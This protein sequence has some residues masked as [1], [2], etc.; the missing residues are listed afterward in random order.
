MRLSR[1]TCVMANMTTG[2]KWGASSANRRLDSSSVSQRIRPFLIRGVDIFGAFSSHCHSTAILRIARSIARCLVLVPFVASFGIYSGT[3]LESLKHLS[4]VISQFRRWRRFSIPST[5][6][7]IFCV[8]IS[9]RIVSPKN[10]SQNVMI[11]LSLS[12]LFLSSF[13]LSQRMQASLKSFFGASPSC[14]T[15]HA[16]DFRRS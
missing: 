4:R 14:L 12:M 5:A 11:L 6:S 2:K 8:V 1:S 7:I 16:S 13:S 15:R 10:C 9:E 3:G